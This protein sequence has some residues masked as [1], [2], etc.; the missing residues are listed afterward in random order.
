MSTE[1]KT[2]PFITPT[3]NVNMT[4]PEEGLRRQVM[5]TTDKLMLVRHLQV[6]GWVGARHKHPHEQ[7]LY[8]VYGTVVLKVENPTTGQD[9]VFTMKKGDSLI[10]PGDR[11]HEAA[12]LEDVEVIDVFTPARDDYR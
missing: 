11:M 4:T 7:L 9:D 2:K 10:V 6:K 1:T 3:D 5:S 8:I 12:A